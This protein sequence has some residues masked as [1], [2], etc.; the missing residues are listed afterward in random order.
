MSDTFSGTETRELAR[1]EGDGTTVVLAWRPLDNRLTV[2]VTDWR[3]GD[4]FELALE[5][6]PPL[7][8]FHHPYAYAA[9]RR[10]ATRLHATLS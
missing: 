3:G 8:V 2:T 6:E 10:S 7:D 1:R 9:S 4:L 5:D